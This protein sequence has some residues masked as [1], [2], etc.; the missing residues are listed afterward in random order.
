MAVDCTVRPKRPDQVGPKPAAPVDV[1][2]GKKD[3]EAKIE[4]A[5][6]KATEEGASP[7]EA[8]EAGE[9]KDQPRRRN[10]FGG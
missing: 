2:V 6:A 9:P 5:Q 1:T 8:L 10:R 3:I 4:A 7:E